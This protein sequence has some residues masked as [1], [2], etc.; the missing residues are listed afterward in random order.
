MPPSF[1]SFWSLQPVPDFGA[2]VSLSSSAL[3]LGAGRGLCLGTRMGDLV[4]G[5]GD[6][7][8]QRNVQSTFIFSLD[9]PL[10]AAQPPALHQL[11]ELFAIEATSC[12]MLS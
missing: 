3:R 1:F 6:L 9:I 2:A 4:S 11:T 10:L 5:V 8:G 12:P 7:E